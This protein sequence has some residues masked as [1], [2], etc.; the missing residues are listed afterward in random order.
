MAFEKA[1][2]IFRHAHQQGYG[3]AA[4]NIFNYET[5][6]LAIREAEV[7]NK[8]VVIAFYP[9]FQKFIDF[10]TV[11]DITRHVARQVRV[12]VGL[13][14]DHSHDPGEILRAMDAGFDSVMYDGSKLPFEENVRITSEIVAIAK[15]RGIDVEAELGVVGSASKAEDFADAAKFT[16]VEQAEE[17]VTRTGCNSLA[18]AVGN[19]HGV[20]VQE[21]ALD[22][23]RIAALCKATGIPLVL[24]GGSGIPDPQVTEA[25]KHGIAKIN[26]ATEYHQAYYNA[27]AARMQTG[28]DRDM[29]GCTRN[30]AEAI[31]AFLAHKINVFNPSNTN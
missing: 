18:V 28:S 1:G 24:H 8:P 20:Y 16:S 31:N 15:K 5:I 23:P 17:F 10:A 25:V 27:V 22:I 30:A 11:A 21:P 26:V 14:L 4:F 3:V 6:A 2:G 29:F 9:G 12:P 13:H 7:Q 19:A